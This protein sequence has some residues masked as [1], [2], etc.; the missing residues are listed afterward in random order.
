MQRN[1]VRNAMPFSSSKMVCFGIYPGGNY[2]EFCGK[3]PP[4]NFYVRRQREK[5]HR[6]KSFLRE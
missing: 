1:P 3:V 4:G 5:N 6:N 2:T